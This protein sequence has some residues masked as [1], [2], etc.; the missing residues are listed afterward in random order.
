[1]HAWYFTTAKQ[2]CQKLPG[3]QSTAS[4]QSTA[5]LANGRQSLLQACKSQMPMPQTEL[6]LHSRAKFEQTWHTKVVTQL[7]QQHQQTVFASTSQQ[8]LRHCCAGA[9][10]L[11]FASSGAHARGQQACGF[12]S[13]C[14]PSAAWALHTAKGQRQPA[15]LA[16]LSAGWQ[17]AVQVL[18]H[19]I[20]VMTMHIVES[21][22]CGKPCGS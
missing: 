11:P 8:L 2:I 10:Q 6:A 12:R 17:R 18:T 9:E 22:V 1:M 19:T 5:A 21:H 14:E 15:L 3:L 16:Q 13:L 4:H 7:T 20:C